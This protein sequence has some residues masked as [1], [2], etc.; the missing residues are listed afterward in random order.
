MKKISRISF[1]SGVA[2]ESSGRSARWVRA[3]GLTALAW[4]L[5]LGAS[6]NAMAT[7]P[8]CSTVTPVTESC[9]WVITTPGCY[10]LQNSLTATTDAGDCIQINSS[11]V[12][13]DLNTQTI[14]GTGGTSTG[15]GVHVLGQ[16]NPGAVAIN[17]VAV[18]GGRSISGF[19]IGVAVGDATGTGTTNSAPFVTNL[20]LDNINVG[21][22]NS[23]GIFLFNTRSSQLSGV[24]AQGSGLV[25]LEI[26]GGSANHVSNSTFTGN[27]WGVA[28]DQSN[29]NIL[30]AI[31]ASSNFGIGF[32]INVANGNQINAPS[33]DSN[34]SAV[35]G[36]G[37]WLSE[38]NGGSIAGGHA[39]SNSSIGIFVEQSSGNH[40]SGIELNNNVHAGIYLGCD[41]VTTG[42]CNSGFSNVPFSNNNSI[43]AN[44]NIKSTGSPSYGIAIDKNN[45][46][47]TVVGNTS[48]ANATLDEYDG[49]K[50]GV[51]NWFANNL[52]TSNASCVH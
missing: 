44:I 23:S 1:A 12:Y 39:N 26:E 52:G 30:S 42:T 20:R 19:S 29:G 21:S 35:D 43:E 38:A 24:S 31:N 22:C 6:T 37:I 25:G 45:K 14:T 11:N 17:N 13:L 15:I 33:A 50:C 41:G 49:N 10:K 9:G 7:V 5:G 34:S 36:Y 46:G 18:Q 16:T 3:L 51:N 4:T 8:N 27:E 2:E 47:N 32:I 48:S 28:V 40:I